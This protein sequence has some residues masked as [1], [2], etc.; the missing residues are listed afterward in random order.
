MARKPNLSTI[1]EMFKKGKDFKLTRQ[2]YI[3][4]TGADIPQRKRYTEKDSAIAKMAQKY[5][6]VVEVIPEVLCLIKID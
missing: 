3:Q 1:E 5:G 6:Y 4:K 2:A